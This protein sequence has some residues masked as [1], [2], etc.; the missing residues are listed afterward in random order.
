MLLET[1]TAF[2]DHG[3]GIQR[4]TE[5]LHIHRATLYQ[6]LK[7]IQQITGCDLDSG[8]DRLMLHL[9]LKLRLLAA[10]YRDHLGGP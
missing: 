1:L 10:A 2:L 6:R 9:G 4:T 3:G 8:E 5:T 7:R